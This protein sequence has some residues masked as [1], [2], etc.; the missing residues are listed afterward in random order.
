MEVKQTGIEG[1]VEIFPAIYD[2]SRGW[3]Y[4][5]YRPDKFAQ[6]G[7]HY[8]FKQDNTSFSKKGV[9]RGMHLQAKPY[10]QAKLVTVL[11][12]KIIDV[13][14]DLRPGS[15]TFGQ[16]YYCP[17]DSVRRNFLMVPEGCA[18][19]FVALEDTLFFYKCSNVYN[20]ESEI[21]IRWNDPTMNIQWSVENPIISEKDQVL[22]TLEELLEKSVISR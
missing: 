17:M 14:V 19:G 21:G 13:V 10:E 6:L 7:I 11:H 3:F 9:I 1:L 22:P 12:G 5:F 20:K 18:H 15:R 4:E 2:D 8:D 16:V